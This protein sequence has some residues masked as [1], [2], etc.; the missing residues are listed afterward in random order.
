MAVSQKTIITTRTSGDVVVFDIEGDLS[1]WASS[2]STLSEFVKTQLASG[3]RRILID[4]E[5]TKFVDSFGIGELI[6][7]YTSI[8][9]LGGMFKVCKLPD[10]LLLQFKITMLDKIIK[11]YPTEKAALEAFADPSAPR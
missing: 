11:V 3:E 2:L 9:N 1:R 4:F 6:A 10:V 5:K 7:S 8:Q